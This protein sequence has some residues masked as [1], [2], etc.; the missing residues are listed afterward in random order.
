MSNLLEGRK[1]AIDA[2]LEAEERRQVQI[3]VKGIEE[4]LRAAIK[5]RA[6]DERTTVSEWIRARLREWA[7]GKVEQEQHST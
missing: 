4:E 3:N 5:K 7:R 2:M 6:I 1:A